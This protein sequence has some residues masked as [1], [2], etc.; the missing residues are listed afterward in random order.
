MISLMR[1][2][3]SVRADP[4]FECASRRAVSSA[5]AAWH[6]SVRS[7][8]LGDDDIK[9]RSAV[10]ASEGAVAN[11]GRAA[12]TRKAQGM[13]VRRSRS[14]LAMVARVASAHTRRSAWL[15]VAS[16]R[17]QVCAMSTSVLAR[18]AS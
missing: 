5:A 14:W 10:T 3:S 12:S 8:G 6:W 15:A 13:S 1:V 17:G 16:L 18:T 11:A 4:L 9:A 2:T 7:A